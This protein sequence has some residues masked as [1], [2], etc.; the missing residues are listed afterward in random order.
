MRRKIL[1]PSDLQHE[2]SQDHTTSVVSEKSA[3]NSGD[4]A[5]AAEQVLGS[6]ASP[7]EQRAQ[8]LEHV[9][10]L[11][12]DANDHGSEEE[13]ED[14]EVDGGVGLVGG[15]D[16][17]DDHEHGAEEGAG[18]STDWEEWYGREDC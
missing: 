7:R 10:S 13:A 18:G 8:V 5:H 11:E 14:R 15:D 12:V 1:L 6:S 4:E 3:G 16:L 9:G 17:E 2:L